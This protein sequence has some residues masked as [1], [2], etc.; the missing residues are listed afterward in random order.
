MV[1]LMANELQ[2]HVTKRVEELTGRIWCS[3][4]QSTR[5][6]EGGIWKILSDGKRR[7]FKCLQCQENH[8]RRTAEAASTVTT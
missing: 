2:K 5:P 8:K 3:N 4:C 1:E 7:R 6:K